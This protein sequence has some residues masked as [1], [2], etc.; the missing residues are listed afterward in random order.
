MQLKNKA[1]RILALIGMEFFMM[2]W[3]EKINKMIVRLWRPNFPMR[4]KGNGGLL[5]IFY[6]EKKLTQGHKFTKDHGMKCYN[7]FYSV[8]FCKLVFYLT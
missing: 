8:V 5:K 2:V 3:L 7:I 6:R 4:E 1:N